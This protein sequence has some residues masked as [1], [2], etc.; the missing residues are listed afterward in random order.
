MAYDHGQIEL[1]TMVNH[2]VADAWSENHI[3]DQNLK[4]NFNM[5][6]YED[7]DSLNI[8]GS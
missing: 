6:I 2:C 3:G 8:S 5:D 1:V 4:T 7:E